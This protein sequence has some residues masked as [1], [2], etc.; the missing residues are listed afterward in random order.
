MGMII[1]LDTVNPA[2]VRYS[3]I[4]C[5][6]LEFASPIKNTLLAPDND[7]IEGEQAPETRS[8]GDDENNPDSEQGI[9]NEYLTGF[10]VIKGVEWLLTAPGPIRMKLTLVR[11]EFTPTT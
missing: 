1:E 6:I 3:R 5:Q 4:F 11:R 7:E 10:Y 2:L 9:V 8:G